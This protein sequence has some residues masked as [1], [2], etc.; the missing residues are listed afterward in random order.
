MGYGSDLKNNSL[1]RFLNYENFSRDSWGNQ[2]QQRSSLGST[3]RGGYDDFYS[4]SD[5]LSYN[6]LSR[7][8]SL[9]QFESLERQLLI[10]EQHASMTSLGNSSPSLLSFDMQN[11]ED[12]QAKN[13]NH[14][15]NNSGNN[16]RRGSQSSLLK[17]YESLDGRLHQTYYDLDKLNF[18][19]MQVVHSAGTD[20]F[21]RNCNM[22][23]NSHLAELRSDSEGSS[24]ESSEPNSRPR[25]VLLKEENTDK[26]NRLNSLQSKKGKSSA[27][28]LSEDSGY[29]E[30]AMA[31]GLRRTKSQ[32]LIKNYE[33]FSEEEEEMENKSL[34]YK[35]NL[36]EF[37]NTA[38]LEQQQNS[39]SSSGNIKSPPLSP[40]LEFIRHKQRHETHS[41]SPVS[42]EV[43]TSSSQNSRT[44]C[45]SSASSSSPSN[46]STASSSSSSSSSTASST[47]SATT[48]ASKASF[49]W[50]ITST[51]NNCTASLLT[52]SPSSCVVD[53]GDD[54]EE[55]PSPRACLAEPTQ[56][57]INDLRLAETTSE[58]NVQHFGGNFKRNINGECLECKNLLNEN[59]YVE[60]QSSSSLLKTCRKCGENICGSFFKCQKCKEN[61]FKNKNQNPLDIEQQQQQHILEK[62]NCP[63]CG[64]YISENKTLY[65]FSERV[66]KKLL[67][68]QYQ[69]LSD[70]HGGSDGGGEFPLD[71]LK[72]NKL[73]DNFKDFVNSE[74]NSLKDYSSCGET[75][76][77]KHFNYVCKANAED[78][79]NFKG[80]Q[81]HQLYSLMPSWPLK[82]CSVPNDL[83]TIG[84]KKKTKK[85]QHN[86]SSTYNQDYIH[87]DQHPDNETVIGQEDLFGESLNIKKSSSWHGLNSK[88]KLVV[89][90]ED[91]N[92]NL[93]LLHRSYYNLSELTKEET[94]RMAEKRL[95]SD[96]ETEIVCKNNFLL[97]EIS[98]HFDKT[99]S[100]LN[101]KPIDEEDVTKNVT[102]NLS[103][104]SSAEE[105]CEAENE[106]KEQVQHV[107]LVIRQPP[108][109]QKRNKDNEK[110]NSLT[111]D[112]TFNAIMQC[113][114][115][116]NGKTFDQDPTILKTS[117]AQ[118][119]EK[120]NFDCK[121]LSSTQDLQRA[122]T[123]PKR[124]FQSQASA[125]KKK[126]LVS[127]TP[128]LNAFEQ[129]DIEDDLFVS[130]AH[131]S[132]HQ[133]PLSQTQK[134]LGIL[135]PAGSRTSFG[136]EVSFCPVV[137]KYCWQEQSSEE[138]ND[139]SQELL[140]REEESED[141]LL[142]NADATVIYNTKENENIAAKF[143][144]ESL[145][146]EQQ[147]NKNDNG[148]EMI[149]NLGKETNENE[150]LEESTTKEQQN[151]NGTL[152]KESEQEQP[153]GE[154]MVFKETQQSS[155]ELLSATL[156]TVSLATNVNNETLKVDAQ[157]NNNKNDK[158]LSENKRDNNTN[159]PTVVVARP[160]SIQ[161]PI[162]SEPPINRAH[163]ILYASQQMLDNFQKQQEH[164]QYEHFKS[165]STYNLTSTQQQQ[166]QK[167][168]SNS[169]LSAE[170]QTTS[171]NKLNNN[172]EVL[173]TKFKHEE[174]HPNSKGFLSRFTNGFRFSLRRNKKKLQQQQQEQKEN[175]LTDDS[176]NSQAKSKSLPNNIKQQQ[177]FIH[178]PLKGPLNKQQHNGNTQQTNGNA[179]N[180]K[181]K[182]AKISNLGSGSSSSSNTT[183]M[184]TNGKQQPQ[185]VTGKPPIPA[186]MQKLQS[187][188]SSQQQTQTQQPL[189]EVG[190]SRFYTETN[191]TTTS[192]GVYNPRSST[193]DF[194][195]SERFYNQ[196]QEQQQQQQQSCNNHTLTLNNANE[197][198]VEINHS[199]NNN[200]QEN[201][202]S[203][204]TT[205]PT[206]A[207]T[208]VNSHNNNDNNSNYDFSSSPSRAS[209]SQKTQMF[210]NLSRQTCSNNTQPKIGLIETNLDTHETIITGKTRSLI[211]IAPQ[212]QLRSAGNKRHHNNI[213]T[214]A[215][216]HHHHH[217]L[218]QQNAD[219]E[220]YDD[221]DDDEVIVRPDGTVVVI[222][223]AGS[224]DN[225]SP[226]SQAA[227]IA[228][229]RRPH[230]SMEFLLDKENQKDVMVSKCQI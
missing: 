181:Q 19:D 95:S 87:L 80:L 64:E 77:T 185:K 84:R 12:L 51:T 26:F 76:T 79:L 116:G 108:A 132:M 141:E 129:E 148:N 165:Q 98:A 114:Q 175:Q 67:E 196:Q 2:S 173:K 207:M 46:A 176:L 39:H 104:S 199:S 171:N 109:R 217:H 41:P 216:H 123:M 40:Q 187:A 83:N 230:K 156:N 24:S 126:S 63:N 190:L 222:K 105:E 103:N 136:K 1:E 44:S 205:I 149:A 223:N 45:S 16:S 155:G 206:T 9:I 166:Q 122:R 53:D 119:L 82:T 151:D 60:Q 153:K 174:K 59:F 47:S 62:E 159:K 157:N 227:Q 143:N 140:N 164:E 92:K 43:S 15:A 75:P 28:N 5:S 133:L 68:Q 118:S 102:L 30:P 200:N 203:V 184:N 33:K 131:T 154:Q 32:T 61:N 115:A 127:S 215:H 91:N 11:Q 99:A 134:P 78:S 106:A 65:E 94:E 142:D 197:E 112:F 120:C 27:E 8:S 113:G 74:T 204:T 226:A 152:V 52:R 100:I 14:S 20:S 189:V 85:P 186:T 225:S 93:G 162:L 220:G 158:S 194:L 25:S 37:K 121:E 42:S 135:L 17:K 88:H 107:Q 167:M 147:P 177:D 209:V 169:S 96:Y 71:S 54:E 208:A 66:R 21:S 89:N 57:S 218:H 214:N 58:E 34:N 146:R 35:D 22:K 219:D 221:N 224:N 192:N 18:D 56:I 161:L 180:K 36:N 3:R 110:A 168:A 179:L 191:N 23:I 73:C 69:I 48:C 70:A 212:Q 81:R 13:S 4:D 201:N 86:Y 137:S 150:T 172:N 10:Q 7:S 138:C 55:V 101:D 50:L 195:N 97:D 111:Q 29:C 31:F 38:T 178:I 229:V 6:S 213:I 170:L 228:S 139:G 90:A 163:H 145:K 49:T 160:L 211:N 198:N 124:R 72:R 210:N 125:N 202:F 117:Y 130:S 188:Q 193:Q 183:T 128:N 144:E 182:G